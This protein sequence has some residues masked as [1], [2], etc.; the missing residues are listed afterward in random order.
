M[1][2]HNHTHAA[3]AKTPDNP[4]EHALEF[5]VESLRRLVE[6]KHLRL[7]QQH[8]A[9]RCALLFAAGKIVGM[10]LEQ[11]R[12]LA[13]PRLFKRQCLAPVSWCVVQRGKKVLN[14]RIFDKQR[15][16]VL[17]QQGNFA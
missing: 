15:L 6:Q 4:G 1:A 11:L 8:L 3:R 12:Q 5:C 10:T 14:D 17:W 7:T 13:E 2:D 9:Q 16:R